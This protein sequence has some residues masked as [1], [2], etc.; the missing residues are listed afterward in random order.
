LSSANKDWPAKKVT[1]YFPIFYLVKTSENTLSF[2][3]ILLDYVTHEITKE[4][5]KNG[6]FENV[7]AG[8]LLKCQKLTSVFYP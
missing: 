6:H 2:P 4:F 5:W 3:C 8:F 7:T 1:I